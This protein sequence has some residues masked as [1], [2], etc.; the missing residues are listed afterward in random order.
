[1][2]AGLGAPSGASRRQNSYRKAHDRR[3]SD[4]LPGIVAHE[5]IRAPAGLLSLGADL[6]DGTGCRAPGRHQRELDLGAHSRDIR[7]VDIFQRIRQILDTVQKTIDLA[8]GELAD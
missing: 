2:A 3:K 7:G 1:M 8:V 4:Y 5:G 6:R